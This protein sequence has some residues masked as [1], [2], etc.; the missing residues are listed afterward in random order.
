ME[1]WMKREGEQRDFLEELEKILVHDSE[2][3][4]LSDDKILERCQRLLE[5]TVAEMRGDIAIVNRK[6][7]SDSLVMQAIE[8]I[9]TFTRTKEEGMS[10]RRQLIEK[11]IVAGFH[12]AESEYLRQRVH[13]PEKLYEGYRAMDEVD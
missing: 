3:D 7:L 12:D 11:L 9:R 2:D 4:F 1:A 8:R 6:D 10:L 13:E 5:L